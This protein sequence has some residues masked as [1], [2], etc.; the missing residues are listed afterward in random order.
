MLSAICLGTV[1]VLGMGFI[2]LLTAVLDCIFEQFVYSVDHNPIWMCFHLILFSYRHAR[3]MSFTNPSFTNIFICRLCCTI[4]VFTSLN[5]K[6]YQT[7]SLF[8]GGC[9]GNSGKYLRLAILTNNE[10]CHFSRSTTCLG[11]TYTC[12]M[13]MR[14]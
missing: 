12:V 1:T 11:Q 7:L 5:A 3:A 14:I 10:K 13:I 9:H 6:V 4:R 2:W 8:N